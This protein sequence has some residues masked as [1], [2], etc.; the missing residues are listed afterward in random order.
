MTI[1]RTN[2]HLYPNSI[3]ST[4]YEPW[5]FS[6]TRNKNRRV[7]DKK[8][9]KHAEE[10]AYRVLSDNHS[11]GNFKALNFH[12]VYVNPRWN[13]KRVAKIGNHIFY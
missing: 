5:Q 7:T 11:L 4:V 1:N 2:S 9:W 12:A 10:V 6:W 8:A 3:C 13:K